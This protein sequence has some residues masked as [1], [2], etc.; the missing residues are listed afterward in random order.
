MRCPSDPDKTFSDDPT[1]MVRAIKFLVKYDFTIDP[2]VAAAIRRNAHKIAEVPQN[3]VSKLLTEAVF[4][5]PK[6]TDTAVSAMDDVGL[7]D[8]IH[9]LAER[10]AAFRTTLQHWAQHQPATV[11]FS[12]SDAGWGFILGRRFRGLTPG[13][14]RSYRALL[15]QLTA[16]QRVD[17]EAALAQPG[18]LV[19]NRRIAR[20]L[21]LKGKDMRRLGEAAEISRRLLLD[22]PRLLRSPAGLTRLV[23]EE[24]RLTR[25]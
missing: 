20:S 19:D 3:A 24:M 13:D 22:D 23:L 9:S 25:S 7:L 8:P 2:G 11:L 4:T 1:R 21:G 17:L 10:D 6:T 12:L 18:R 15:P 16:T 5:D 14:V